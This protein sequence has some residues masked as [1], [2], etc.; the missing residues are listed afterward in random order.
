MYHADWLPLGHQWLLVLDGSMQLYAFVCFKSV[1][2]QPNLLHRQQQE[3]LIDAASFYWCTFEWRG[4]AAGAW[5]TMPADTEYSLALKSRR[6]C[7]A[8]EY[9]AS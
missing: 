5:P 7:L 3:H 2:Q 6:C 8:A 1:Q 4:S 9:S